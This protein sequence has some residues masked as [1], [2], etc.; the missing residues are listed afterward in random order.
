M[1]NNIVKM[2]IDRTVNVTL[3]MFNSNSIYD[4]GE[5]LGDQVT[6][7]FSSKPDVFYTYTV[8][9][10]EEWEKNLDEVIEKEESVGKFINT[11]IKN[12]VLKLNNK[13][14]NTFTYS[15]LTPIAV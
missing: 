10:P 7:R 9:N 13:T 3:R 11:S 5:L 15:V 2:T 8:Q 4:I 1:K 14:K 6:I 12:K